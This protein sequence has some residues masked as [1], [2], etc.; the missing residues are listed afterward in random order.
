MAIIGSFK[1][2]GEEFQG[3]IVTLAT[4]VK[5]IRIIPVATPSGDKAP[6]HRVYLDGSEI[7]ACWTKQS[8]E[9][10]EYLSISLDDPSL[11]AP[12]RAN[13][14]RDEDGQGFTLTWSRTRRSSGD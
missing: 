9:G 14:F 2:S 11:P 5:G 13:L 6:S 1:K 10:R 4:Q 3:K 7:G 12:I 8:S